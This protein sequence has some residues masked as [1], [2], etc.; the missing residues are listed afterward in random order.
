M[1]AVVVNC[2]LK[3]APEPSNTDALAEV[4]TGGLRE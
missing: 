2:T 4:V 3:R 1:R